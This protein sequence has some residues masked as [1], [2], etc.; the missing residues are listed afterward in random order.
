MGAWLRKLLNVR[1][2]EGRRTA[3]LYALYFLMVMGSVWGESASEALFI[4]R[5]GLSSFSILFI[6]EAVFTLVCTVLYTAFVDRLSHARLLAAI[7]VVTGVSLLITGLLL[8]PGLPIA[9]YLFYLI[10]RTTRVIFTVHIWTYIGEYYDTR[11]A[12]RLFPLIGSAGR[13]SGFLGGMA[14]P[15]VVRTVHAENIPYLWIGVLAVAAWMCLSIPRWVGHVAVSSAAPRKTGLVEHF[16]GGWQAIRSSSLLQLLALGAVTM[17]LL[18]ALINVQ[19]NYVFSRT[20]RS[21]DEL[22]SLFGVLTGIANAIALPFQLFLLTR[23]VNRLGVGWTNL[24]YPVLTVTSYGLL[25]FFPFLPLAILG[26]F[27]RTAFRWGI[28]NPV[29]NMLYNAVSRTVKGR[30]RAFVNAML[31]PLATFLAGAMLLPIPRGGSL[32]TYLF[33]LGG[34]VGLVY[35]IVAWRTRAAYRQELLQTLTV[36]DTD[37]HQLVGSPWDATDRAALGYVLTR[38]RESSNETN[39]LFL[40]ELAYEIGGSDA[41]PT[42]LELAAG[43]SPIIRAGILEIIGHEGLANPRVRALCTESLSDPEAIVRRTALAVLEEHSGSEDLPL[44]GLALDHLRD[45]DPDVRA[46]AISLLLRSGDL[47]YLTTAAG[48]LHEMLSGGDPSLRALAASVLGEIGD[49]RVVRTLAPCLDDPAESVRQAAM[50]AIAAVASATAPTWVRQI[51]ME[52]ARKALADL[53]EGVRMAAVQALGRLGAAEAR[54]LLVDALRDDSPRL[55]ESARQALER[56]GT[57]VTAELSALLDSEDDRVRGAAVLTLLN[58]STEKY[59][60]RADEEIHQ[61][62]QRIYHHLIL[63]D[64]LSPFPYRGA[65][66]AVDTLQERNRDLLEHVFRILAAL[67]GQDCVQVIQHNLRSADPHTR[68]NAIEALEAISSPSIARLVAPL[69][70]MRDDGR[71][72]RDA[73]ALAEQEFGQQPVTPEAAVEQMLGGQDAWL[74]AVVLHLLG[75][76]GQSALTLLDAPRLVSRARREE[77]IRSALDAPDR[78]VAETARRVARQFRLLSS[79]DDKEASMLSTIE[80]VIFL[81]EVPF[82]SEMTIG[83]IRALAGIAEEVHYEDDQVIFREGEAGGTLYVIV[84]GRVAI[85]HQAESSSGSVARLATLEARQYFGES[86]IFDEL[87]RSASAIA[88]GPTHLLS[89][90]KEPLVALV[91]TDPTLALELIRVLSLRLRQ[92]NEQVAS[93]TRVRPRQL[94]KLYD[95]LSSDPP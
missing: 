21:A 77:A 7:L 41:L 80:R 47:F 63:T 35:L 26:L 88:V 17:T 55:R 12:R 75:E 3:L 84:S 37:L 93:R 18:L 19:A 2:G 45:P 92:A 48:A 38:A 74:S 50:Q 91:Q 68:A 86:S 81:K 5:V 62:L 89:I 67:H 52:S 56:A 51:T 16:R 43:R 73:I 15:F 42:L 72:P 23:I 69:V 66:L 34:V 78:L 27:V 46:R 10:G 58:L 70:E 24:S 60:K 32:P 87:P 31:V 20:Y 11:A 40:A 4:E 90:R 49:P 25:T 36:E 61:A 14:F 85:E 53:T 8:A 83:Q 9:F 57:A 76:A 28:N 39:T 22:G 64:A 1:A 29:D 33:V 13:V 65:K 59:R 6:T 79:P 71:V 94:E 95:Q 54:P 44:L 82:F 30:A